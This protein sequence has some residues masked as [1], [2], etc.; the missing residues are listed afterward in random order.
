M[1]RYR[2]SNFGYR[3]I[4]IKFW[5]SLV[6]AAAA[7]AMFS[8]N[9]V[10]VTFMDFSDS[11]SPVKLH[12]SIDVIGEIFNANG[13]SLFLR[14]FLLL[15]AL[16]VI[17]LVVSMFMY[18]H[19]HGVRLSYAGF[20]SLC[21]IF[22]I[23]ICFIIYINYCILQAWIIK[24]TVFPFAG[25]AVTIVAMIFFTER[26]ALGKGTDSG[27]SEADDT[28]DWI[29]IPRSTKTRSSE[30]Q[31]KR[32]EEFE[33][34]FWAVLII[35]ALPTLIVSS[36]IGIPENVI[37]IFYGV[38]WA[39]PLLFYAAKLLVEPLQETPPT[40]GTTVKRVVLLAAF[41]L[42]E[43]QY[44]Y[45]PVILK[46]PVN[47]AAVY[48]A[49]KP[50]IIETEYYDRG[51]LGMYKTTGR[52]KTT[53]PDDDG[54]LCVHE[55]EYVRGIPNGN[56][57]MT[58]ADGTVYSGG[59]VDGA[60]NG[61]GVMTWTN[62]NVYS[63]DF[64]NGSRTGTGV[65]TW[66]DGSCY[67]GEWL[68][69]AITGSGILYNTQGNIVY[70]GGWKNSRFNGDGTYYFPNGTTYRTDWS[71]GTCND[72]EPVTLRSPSTGDVVV[73][74]CWLDNSFHGRY[75]RDGAWRFIS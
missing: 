48:I 5:I 53:G 49:G 22:F 24:F 6:C 74:G 61:T 37:R 72:G 28:N 16:S 20:G 30:E 64:T 2:K 15:S 44:T 35:I 73:E 25:M 43:L 36:F 45:M 10:K 32:I 71:Y 46:H 26:S 42:L 1:N 75:L 17:L 8:F 18:T 55:G 29:R 65:C 63:G 67:T 54:D 56:G 60:Q 47:A 38:F 31:K 11:F 51:F 23:F 4:N 9:W 13:I 12:G 62:G 59:F 34:T 57:T 40:R 66:A 69:G 19:K 33:A 39:F 50:V 58:W 52:G 27:R 7:A 14:L 70:S 41:I 21:A 3:K 68:N